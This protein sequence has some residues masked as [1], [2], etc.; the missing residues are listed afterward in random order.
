MVDQNPFRRQVELSKFRCRPK[1]IPLALRTSQIY[2]IKGHITAWWYEEEGVIYIKQSFDVH[3]LLLQ[4]GIKT[5]KTM[6][7]DGGDKRSP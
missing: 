1:Y 3:G 4:L 2:G 7:K 6:A 5:E